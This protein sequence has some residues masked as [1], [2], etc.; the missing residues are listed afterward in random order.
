LI[1]NLLACTRAVACSR[2]GLSLD[3]VHG[4]RFPTSV[5]QII[6]LYQLVICLMQIAISAH[7]IELRPPLSVRLP[8]GLNRN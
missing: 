2:N 5:L 4:D 1:L 7:K 8:I 3:L 6:T